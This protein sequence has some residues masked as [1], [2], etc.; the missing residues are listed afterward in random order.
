MRI[1]FTARR[2][3]TRTHNTRE[4]DKEEKDGEDKPGSNGSDTAHR[5]LDSSAERKDRPLTSKGAL[6]G[7][8]IVLHLIRNE[9]SLNLS[10]SLC[11]FLSQCCCAASSI[12]PTS[13][14][15]FLT[16]Q[17]IFPTRSRC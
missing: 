12:E 2:R 6:N 15:P 5:D 3:W 1:Q 7:I 17:S 11:L 13:H 14:F 8:A 10:L 16:S 4:R 9:V